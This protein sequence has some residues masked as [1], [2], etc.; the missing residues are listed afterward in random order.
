LDVDPCF[1][2]GHVAKFSENFPPNHRVI[3]SVYSYYHA[4]LKF[5]LFTNILTSNAHCV[6][7]LSSRTIPTV[8]CSLASQ[9]MHGVIMPFN[10]R[11]PQR[12][13]R[14]FKD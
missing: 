9:A 8:T 7:F 14:L 12:L 4:K 11:M 10:L 3:S 6:F 1:L 13:G 2:P 5:M